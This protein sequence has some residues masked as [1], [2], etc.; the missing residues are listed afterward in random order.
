MR[1]KRRRRLLCLACVLTALV[2]VNIIASLPGGKPRAQRPLARGERERPPRHR[3]G[4]ALGA[5]AERQG[6]GHA[7]VLT[8]RRPGRTHDGSR[9]RAV[10][11]GRQRFGDDSSD[12]WL[13]VDPARRDEAKAAERS[14]AGDAVVNGRAAE[15]SRKRRAGRVDGANEAQEESS[16]VELIKGQGGWLG[17]LGG[18][19]LAG[20]FGLFHAGREPGPPLKGPGERRAPRNVPRIPSKAAPEPGSVPA[21]VPDPRRCAALGLAFDGSSDGGPPDAPAPPPWLSREDLRILNLLSGGA[22]RRKET[23]PGHG[24]VLRLTMGAAGGSASAGPLPPV[25]A[26]R[27]YCAEG[28][29]ALAKRT[30]DSYEVLAFHLDRVLGLGRAPPAVSRRLDSWLLPYRFTNGTARP[31]IWWV[32]DILRLSDGASEEGDDQNSFRLTWPQYQAVLRGE[33]HGSPGGGGGAA[34]G[35]GAGGGGGGAAGVSC[36]PVS[37]AEWGRLALFD[38]LLQVYDR[39][40]RGCCGFIPDPRDS[41]VE[42][43]FIDKCS[44]PEHQRL[45]HVVVRQSNPSRLVFI[46]NAGRPFQ[47]EDNLNFRMLQGITQFP[48]LAVRVLESPCFGP[49]LLHSLHLD[50]IFWE[51]QGGLAGVRRLVVAIEAR[52]R[53]LLRYIREHGI[54]TASN[55]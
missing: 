24:A 50:K 33:C 25:E 12:E 16:L 7:E 2:L 10:R 46:D 20:R 45:V 54:A 21:P 31:L 28:A 48:A 22:V 19:W 27:D 52:G 11:G 23:L 38:F 15:A 30:G 5:G 34:K 32:P 1:L 13:A 55:A 42:Q 47:G 8:E 26:G 36:P 40:D 18:K 14:A 17:E 41:C 51:S 29:C 49:A 4:V 44:R 3:G 9:P 53:I 35:D 43:G 6:G 37:R 39:L